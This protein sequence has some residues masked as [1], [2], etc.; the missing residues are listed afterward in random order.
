MS[1]RTT[2]GLFGRTESRVLLPS[3]YSPVGSDDLDS[4]SYAG[5]ASIWGTPCW[6]AAGGFDPT[7]GHRS[8]RTPVPERQQIAT[9]ADT[10][11]PFGARLRQ[12]R[13]GVRARRSV[14]D[15]H[16]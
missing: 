3:A 2:K 5:F 13:S 14:D 10:S 9:P 12:L 8:N 16:A 6:S 4:A 15:G 1:H 11:M 7:D